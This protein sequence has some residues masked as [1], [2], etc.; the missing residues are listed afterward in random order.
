[1]LPV[2]TTILLLPV[3]VILF[4]NFNLF[5]QAKSN[6]LPIGLL[7]IFLIRIRKIPQNLIVEALIRLHRSNLSISV[8]KLQEHYLAGGN[9]NDVVEAFISANRSKLPFDFD[10]LCSIDLAGRD[11]LD[12]VESYV[13]PQVIHCPVRGAKNHTW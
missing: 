4:F 3:A 8:C 5:I 2:I 13:S 11:V 7:E 10:R 12:A 6:G 9:L 1:M